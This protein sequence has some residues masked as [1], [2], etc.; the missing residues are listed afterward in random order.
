MLVICDS[1]KGLFFS[2]MITQN[3]VFCFPL[4]IE[5]Y[6]QMSRK[7]QISPSLSALWG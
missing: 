4:L 2:R 3:R 5:L 7:K 1:T 6:I